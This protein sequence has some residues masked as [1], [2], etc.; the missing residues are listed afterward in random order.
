M[1]LYTLKLDKPRR[2]K[3]GFKALAVIEERYAGKK[4]LG[5]IMQGGSKEI[6]FLAWLGLSGE[7]ESLTEE[8]VLD[9]LDNA[10]P[11]TYTVGGLVEIICDVITAQMGIKKKVV[12]K[13]KKTASRTT[14]GKRSK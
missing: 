13:K 1:D 12:T 11:D 14:V 3:Y 4:D 8:K 6:P 2:L 10:I 5:D 9:L 7:D